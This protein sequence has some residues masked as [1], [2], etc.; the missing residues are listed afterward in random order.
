MKTFWVNLKIRKS[1]HFFEI[2]RLLDL[3]GAMNKKFQWNH[4]KTC[5][6]TLRNF[7]GHFWNFKLFSIFFRIFPSFDPPGCTGHFF[8]RINL[9]TSSKLV[10]TL[11]ETCLGILNFEKFLH[12]FE[13][14]RRLY[15]PGC[16]G[17]KISKKS[18]QNM[19][20]QS[21]KRFW[22]F[23]KIWILF[24]FCGTFS[25]LQG[26]LGR[27]F[28]RRNNHAEHDQTMFL[29]TFLE[30]FES[31]EVF[32]LFVFFASFDHPGCTGQKFLPKKLPLSM[33]KT[34]LIAF[35]NVFSGKLNKLNFFQFF[36][37]FPSF[38]P[39]GCTGQEKIEK[40]TSCKFGHFLKRFSGFWNFEIFSIFVDFSWVSRVH[41]SQRFPSKKSIKTFSGNVF[42]NVFGRFSKIS[43]FIFFKVFSKPRPSRV[44]WRLFSEEKL[45]QS[46][47][48]KCLDNFRDSFGHFRN[49]EIFHFFQS[50]PYSTLQ[51][52]LGTT[53]TETFTS[54]QVQNMFDCFWERFL[55][56]LK[57]WKFFRFFGVFPSF[58]TPGCTGHFF[59]KKSPQNNFK[60]CL[61]TFRNVFGHFWNFK[62]FSIFFSNFSKFRPSR[63]HWSN[64][65]TKKTTSKHVQNVFDLFG[66]RFWA[67]WKKKWKFFHF[68]GVFPCFDPPGC[69]G[70]NFFQKNTSKQVQ[71]LFGNF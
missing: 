49:I 60:T 39:P 57:I 26:A 8:S 15:P 7:F 18:H 71:N 43:E 9:E 55:G 3:Q 58:D 46:R 30:I 51:G 17:Q 67:F 70:Q 35:G 65:F 29:G 32:P 4:L 38:D 14:F 11:L 12:F 33:L 34:C 44:H 68:S 27:V 13:I 31:F 20:G 22:T 63:V 69:T 64:F 53:F 50:F 48:G 36:E 19:F 37:V 62:F 47:F 52:A 45:P 61:D 66:E 25:S 5:L 24:D 2:F 10:W 54:K 59:P 21:W 16:N 28:F 41:W 6:D 1:F 56:I 40:I 42:G 23:L